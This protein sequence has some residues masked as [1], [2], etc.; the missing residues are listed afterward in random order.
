MPYF[1]AWKH[2]INRPYT[3]GDDIKLDGV[4][5]KSPILKPGAVAVHRID[6]AQA[7]VGR[8]SVYEATAGKNYRAVFWVALTPNGAP[9]PGP[10]SPMQPAGVQMSQGGNVM[11][12]IGNVVPNQ[13]NWLAAALGTKYVELQPGEAWLCIYNDTQEAAQFGITGYDEG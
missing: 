8:I 6:A 5:H 4:R 9:L 11:L 12:D 10:T 13:T 3:R 1:Q 7:G 2:D